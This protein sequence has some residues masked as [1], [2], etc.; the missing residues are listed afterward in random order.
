MILSLYFL[1]PAELKPGRVRREV[2]QFRLFYFVG[3]HTEVELHQA[4]TIINL[5]ILKNVHLSNGF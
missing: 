2:S 4:I 3:F 1:K 5:I